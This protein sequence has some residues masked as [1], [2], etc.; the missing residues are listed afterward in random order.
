MRF[1][2]VTLHRLWAETTNRLDLLHRCVRE[3]KRVLE[4]AD[5]ARWLQFSGLLNLFDA[6]PH[7][8]PLTVDARTVRKQISDVIFEAGELFRNG[9]SDPKYAASDIAEI[10]RKLDALMRQMNQTSP[11]LTEAEASGDTAEPVLFA[12]QGGA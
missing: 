5:F 11:P 8:A 12:I 10:N 7:P 4:A 1:D 9:K 3:N 6:F 2:S